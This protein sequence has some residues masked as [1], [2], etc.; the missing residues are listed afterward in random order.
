M[1]CYIMHT[2]AVLF[3]VIAFIVSVELYRKLSMEYG[4]RRAKKKK[5]INKKEPSNF[6]FMPDY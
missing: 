1:P 4:Y 5:K 3:R 6:Y 2:M